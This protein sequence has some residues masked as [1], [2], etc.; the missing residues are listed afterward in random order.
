[1]ASCGIMAGL[2]CKVL[3]VETSLS[4]LKTVASVELSDSGGEAPRI[5]SK[6][7]GR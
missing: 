2:S 5:I 3:L 4:R 1:M 7:A 6:T